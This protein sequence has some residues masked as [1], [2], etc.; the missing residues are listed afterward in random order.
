[1]NKKPSEILSSGIRRGDISGNSPLYDVWDTA[2]GLTEELREAN[3]AN[4]LGPIFLLKD[5]DIPVDPTVPDLKSVLTKL[6]VKTEDDPTGVK[7]AR[8]FVDEFP[9]KRDAWKKKIEKDPAF[10]TRGWNTVQDLFKQTSNDLMRYDIAENR[11]KIAS[12]EDESGL[13]WLQAQVANFMFPRAVKAV[14]EGRSPSSGEWA[15]DV[16]AN[17]AYAVPV[18]RIL[19]GVTKA[20]PSIVKGGVQAA[21]QFA[22]P[23]AVAGMDRA[24]DPNYDSG[25]AA[26][27]IAVGGLTNLGVNRIL[28]PYLANKIGAVSGKVTRGRLPTKIRDILEGSPSAQEKAAGLV[29]D[30]DR[31]LKGEERALAAG[32]AS[33][34]APATKASLNEARL[35]KEIAAAPDAPLTTP[36]GRTVLN[37]ATGKP[38]TGKDLVSIIEKKKGDELLAREA[39]DVLGSVTQQVTH[40]ATAP[41]VGGTFGDAFIEGKR[42]YTDVLRSHPELKSVFRPEARFLSKDIDASRVLAPFMTYSVNMF[43]SGTDKAANLAGAA[44]GTDAKEMRESN[45]KRR[46]EKAHKVAVSEILSGDN[47]TAEDK[48]YLEKLKDHPEMLKFSDDSGFKT[49]LLKRGHQLLQGT[50]AHRPLWEVE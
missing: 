34:A 26:T 48:E 49:W 47:L 37:G 43:G 39:E 35:I 11:R 13:G 17:A 21:G 33:D 19:G 14:E 9:K 46:A 31:L 50:P 40:P 30:A 42:S 32:L 22:A 27:D 18:S 3:I 2:S 23:A 12:G 45:E 44:L 8:K 28:G 7:A 24:F 1:M 16:A 10:G 36:D 29:K 20:A 25:D 5:A 6:G 15:R 41:R 4:T 38:L